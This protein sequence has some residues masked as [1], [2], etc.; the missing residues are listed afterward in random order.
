M[1]EGQ[2]ISDL[3]QGMSVLTDLR[4]LSLDRNN[5]EQVPAVVLCYSKLHSLTMRNNK[6]TS[7]TV[8]LPS[9]LP[10][11]ETLAVEGNRLN[12]LPLSLNT[13]R[14]LKKVTYNDNPMQQEPT[15]LK[16]CLKKD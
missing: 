1:I 9:K 14:K 5:F 10:D 6:L 4:T 2:N 7:L 13:L 12:E 8:D 3:P 11:L 15:W 16:D